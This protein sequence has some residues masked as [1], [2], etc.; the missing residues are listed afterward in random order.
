MTGNLH[1]VLARVAVRGKVE[2]DYSFVERLTIRCYNRGED[3]CAR[4]R[5]S[6]DATTHLPSYGECFRTADADDA[7]GTARSSGEGADGVCQE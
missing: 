5:V 2:G 1:A 3:G 6:R 7:D 4:E